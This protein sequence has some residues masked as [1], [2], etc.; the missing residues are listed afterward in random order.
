M[1]SDIP[2]LG[3]GTIYV[4]EDTTS[5]SLPSLAAATI[6]AAALTPTRFVRSSNL[7]PVGGNGTYKVAV[8]SFGIDRVN[9]GYTFGIASAVS[10]GVTPTA[11]QGINVRIAS[12]EYAALTN[13]DLAVGFAIFLQKGSAS[14][15][16]LNIGIVDTS[17]DFSFL[18]MTE[19]N[20]AAAKVSTAN[21]AAATV[22]T[23]DGSRAP[24]GVNFVKHRTSGG[25]RRRHRAT[26]VPYTPDDSVDSTLTTARAV[27]LEFN[28]LSDGLDDLMLAQGGDF[29]IYTDTNSQVVSQGAA[30]L[31]TTTCNISGNKAIKYDMAN[32]TDGSHITCLHIGN[33]VNNQQEWT[34]ERRKNEASTIP[35]LLSATSI[36]RL[37]VGIQTGSYLIRN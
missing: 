35:Y 28:V 1:P 7:R 5:G 22:T 6:G 37:L 16:L 30:D 10:S 24:G 26:T 34:E 25:V 27:D 36:D 20:P 8:A 18:V 3:V 9:G 12:S 32:R 19:A 14:P 11:G 33:V 4:Q 17:Q 21:L 31:Y 2:G 29:V 23:Q 13:V 15:Q